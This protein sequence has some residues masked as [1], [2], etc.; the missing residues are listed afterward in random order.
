M[1]SWFWSVYHTVQFLQ[2]Q[3]IVTCP[4]VQHESAPIETAARHNEWYIHT[5]GKNG[6]SLSAIVCVAK[7]LLI[8]CPRL[9]PSAI[10]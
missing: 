6:K 8:F 10:S 3:T 2:S 5:V 9:M 1:A 7:W 4:T